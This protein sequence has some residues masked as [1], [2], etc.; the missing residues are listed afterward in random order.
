M[1]DKEKDRINLKLEIPT[2]EIDPQ[3]DFIN[4][5]TDSGVVV[6]DNSL[7]AIDAALANI[8]SAQA[9]LRQTR[10]RSL[11]HSEEK[12]INYI[13]SQK[14]ST[15]SHR[16]PGNLTPEDER[17]YAIKIH[18]ELKNETY[19]NIYGKPYLYKDF[20]SDFEKTTKSQ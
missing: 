9:D 14:N 19:I 6:V 7:S 18:D 4:R 16:F 8:N 1:T 15:Y 17:N 3:A 12:Y 2:F 5:M 10:N 20:L 13:I 11:N